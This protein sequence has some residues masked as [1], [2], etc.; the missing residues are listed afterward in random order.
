MQRCGESLSD[1]ENKE[2]EIYA[3]F[4]GDTVVVTGNGPASVL[5]ESRKSLKDACIFL[6]D[7]KESE[8][9]E[10]ADV[11]NGPEMFRREEK[12][13]IQYT[14]LPSHYRDIHQ[15]KLLHQ[16]NEKA[17]ERFNK[18][19]S[20]T[21]L[22]KVAEEREKENLTQQNA[23]ILST[24]KGHPKLDHI[25]IRRNIV[26]N[27]VAGSLEAHTNG[28]R[29][30][31]VRG[32]KTDILYANIKCSFFQSCYA[33]FITLLH[34]HLKHAIVL[35]EEE[36]FDLQF[37]VRHL[38]DISHNSDELMNLKKF[39]FT[40]EDYKRRQ[41][42]YYE[43]LKLFSK[44]YK[45]AESMTK[46]LVKFG[47]PDTK[48]FLSGEISNKIVMLHQTAESLVNLIDWPP[49]LII[50]KEVE[51][52]HFQRTICDRRTINIVFVFKD[53]YKDPAQINYVRMNKI[54]TL[55]KWLDS[56]DLCF[57][58]THEANWRQR[59]DNILRDPETFFKNGGWS[60]C[61]SVVC[62]EQLPNDRLNYS[63]LSD[64]EGDDVEVD[65][66][67]NCGTLLLILFLN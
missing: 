66:N 1:L 49:L 54:Y 64:D 42:D 10:E 29:F 7:D 24:N 6:S 18:Q 2:G 12:S 16:L 20:T 56:V 28:F 45:D 15:K 62:K 30:T 8:K 61:K 36:L 17:R 21:P 9:E 67:G 43:S 57:S 37:Y 33:Y 4:V 46:N 25:Y 23:L 63:W 13:K 60:Y 47:L 35:G 59:L 51:F 22:E 44:F 41:R 38:E 32:D 14:R 19:L 53:Y 55:Q 65:N 39:T 40:D 31:S 48:F 58:T 11:H 52:A 50:F 5:T 27:Q 3:L 34:F 26:A